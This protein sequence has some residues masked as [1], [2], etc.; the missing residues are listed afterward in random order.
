MWTI[1]LFLV[2]AGIVLALSPDAVALVSTQFDAVFPPELRW[3]AA[4][5]WFDGHQSIG[6]VYLSVAFVFVTRTISRL[7]DK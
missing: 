6:L 3:K 2:G 4:A 5:T 7:V 1:P